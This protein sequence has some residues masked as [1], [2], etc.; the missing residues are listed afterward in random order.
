MFNIPQNSILSGFC[1]VSL[2][3]G[4]GVLW[5]FCL[6]TKTLNTSIHMKRV[7]LARKMRAIC[8]FPG[9]CLFVRGTHTGRQANRKTEQ[10]GDNKKITK[11]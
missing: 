2:I 4:G 3:S 7:F 11:T 10:Q 9:V 8:I 5:D 6:Q 1:F